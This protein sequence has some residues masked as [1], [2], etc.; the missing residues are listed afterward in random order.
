MCIIISSHSR[1]WLTELGNTLAG[2]LLAWAA[3]FACLPVLLAC[4]HRSCLFLH[5]W[6]E[7]SSDF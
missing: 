7:F 1:S 2:C 5:L 6:G 4:L 3:R